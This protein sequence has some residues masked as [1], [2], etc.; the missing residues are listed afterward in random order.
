MDYSSSR[1]SL[2]SYEPS[3]TLVS[4][5]TRIAALCSR[6]RQKVG[7]RFTHIVRAGIW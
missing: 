7:A 6:L 1:S 4:T 5:S 2:G 3:K